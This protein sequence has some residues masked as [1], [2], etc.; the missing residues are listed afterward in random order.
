[1]RTDHLVAIMSFVMVFPVVL[2]NA[3]RAT[4]AFCSNAMNRNGNGNGNRN[5]HRGRRRPLSVLQS[6]AASN[7]NTPTH[8]NIHAH[9]H[10]HAPTQN[11]I[12]ES[13]QQEI[14]TLNGGK[15]LNVQSPKQVSTAVFGTPQ[16]ATKSVLQQAANDNNDN[17]NG[18]LSSL[19]QD[20]RRLAQLILECRSQMQRQKRAAM[21]SMASLSLE[22]EE[23]EEESDEIIEE[24][25]HTESGHLFHGS[26]RRKMN[27]NTNS[28][29]RPPS[30]EQVVDGLFA[31]RTNLMDEYWK[32]PLRQLS[33]GA[34]RSL[35]HQLDPEHC[36]MGYNPNARPKRKGIVG[37]AAASSPSKKGTFLSYCREQ[38]KLYPQCVL[39]VRCGDF[40]E[41]FGLDAV[42]LVEHVG[43]NPMAG[44]ARAGCPYRNIQATVDGLT[45]QGFSVAVY[46][47][48]GAAATHK[49]KERVLTQIVSPA[50]PTYLYDNW[51]LGADHG[52]LEG[53]PPSRPCVGIVHTSSGYQLIE[54]S[55]EERSV[56][57]SER[58]TPEAVACRLAAYPPADPLV[59]IPSPT[60]Q[61]TSALPF[62]PQARTTATGDL[63]E[64]SLGGFRIRTK[65]LPPH[66]VPEPTCGVSDADRYIQAVVET[67]LQLNERRKEDDDDS[68]TDA[69]SQSSPRKRPTADDFTIS[70]ASTATNPLYMETASQLG[71]LKDPS[72]PSLTTYV[73]D[74]AAPA[75][76]R[77]FLQRYLL[78]PPPPKVAQAMATLVES[79][80]DSDTAMALP[81][82]TVPPLGKVLSLVR[83]GQASANIYGDLLQSLSTTLFVLHDDQP[84]PIDALLV[85]CE[86]ESGLAA[87]RESLV[88]RCKEAMATMEA[89]ISPAYHVD[90]HHYHEDDDGVTHDRYLPFAFFERNE[91]PWRG[92]VQ[93]KVAE[94]MYQQVHKAADR[95]CQAVANDF[96]VGDDSNQSLMV[97]DIFNNLI[98]LKQLPKNG[99]KE[100]YFHPRDRHGKL[101][102]TRYTTAHVQQAVSDYVTA[103][104]E[105]CDEVSSILSNLA[106]TLQDEG[107]IPAI[108]QSTHL[109]LVLSAAFHHAVKATQLKWHLAETIEPSED[110]GTEPARFVNLWPYWMP[111]SQAVANSFD[112]DGMFLLTA[113]NMSGKSTLMRSTAAAALLTVCGLCAPLQ[114]GSRIPRFDTLFLR[115]ASADVPAENK[116]AFGAEMGD[117]AAL[118]RCC[119]PESLIFV[120]ELGRGTSPRDGTRL[121]GAVLEAMAKR[122]MSGIF[123]THLH[124]ILDLP[125]ERKDRIITKRM[126]IEQ[127]EE[128][129]YDWTYRLE[130]GVCTDSLALVTAARFGLPDEI[131]RRAEELAGFLPERAHSSSIPNTVNVSSVDSDSDMD[132][133]LD[134]DMETPP[135]PSVRSPPVKSGKNEQHEEDFR[136][137]VALAELVTGQSSITIPPRWSPPASL[138]N[139]SCVYLVEV[140]HDPPRYY[141]GE[142]DSL[143]QRLRQHRRKGSPWSQSRAVAVPVASKSQA[144][145]WENVLIQRMAQS[146]FSMES[147][148]DGRSLLRRQL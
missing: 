100:L 90:G 102:R 133:D 146:G 96:I 134:S 69:N 76:T 2:V 45:Q 85:L 71:L 60:E 15:P 147:V 32:D 128:K 44:K 25:V 57:F 40:Y 142:T 140:A 43:L 99:D 75:A 130:D 127:T 107:H 83:A 14:Q 120:D 111:H 5:R 110:G 67:L 49:I 79:L 125:L 38:K 23:E 80:M 6:N 139:K 126:A 35:T 98:A 8:D 74:E 42:L 27:T 39:L 13:L 113:P 31:R 72:I 56:E 19:S 84:L 114:E 29:K 117:V 16:S 54:V 46:E 61:D 66:L 28:T 119:G 10:A 132:S 145:A 118:L 48:V 52:S 91:S 86:H 141:V 53:L 88:R 59:Y 34:A 144:R 121:A 11:P 81:P 17:D 18:E 92:R 70:M 50:A 122:E 112:L 101:L 93:Q 21:S 95:L 37:S 62:L 1:M 51:L 30:H 89:V 82:L 138:G 65:V 64:S 9:T 106:Q 97:Q 148:T 7:D 105:A 137:A 36:P 94:T 47:E 22:E 135:P 123:A 68:S 41:T 129:S 108:A 77:R 55:L 33:R 104:D 103:C 116:S 12:V 78:I 63:V 115:G 3:R 73:L 109:N 143:P 4:S 136:R 124:D 58:L 131:I 87:E 24:E 26:P 20:K